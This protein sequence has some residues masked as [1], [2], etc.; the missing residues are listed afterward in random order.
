MNRRP[1]L[2]LALVVASF[3][4]SA[5]SSMTGPRQDDICSGSVTSDGRCIP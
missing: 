3:V 5:C 2:I 4:A 1:L